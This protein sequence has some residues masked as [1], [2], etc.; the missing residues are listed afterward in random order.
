MNKN[1]QI[2]H[3]QL[4]LSEGS[5]SHLFPVL[6]DLHQ[7]ISDIVEANFI[8][9]IIDQQYSLSTSVIGG[10]NRFEAFLTCRIP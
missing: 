6:V 10:C 5:T 4:T 3:D 8:R 7:P 2:I 1:H 9:Y